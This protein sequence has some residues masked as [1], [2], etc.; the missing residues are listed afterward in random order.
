MKSPIRIGIFKPTN[1]RINNAFATGQLE[2]LK[3]LQ[4]RND[5]EIVLL[6][7]DR[8]F[9][10]NVFD[11]KHLK[12]NYIKTY[13]NKI[14]RKLFKIPYIKI[15]YYKNLDLNNF[16]TIITEGIH[17]PHL[18]YLFGLKCKIIFNDSITV[19][20]SFNKRK[21]ELFNK[22][23]N[24]GKSVVVNPKIKKLYKKYN[25]KIKSIVIGHSVSDN[26]KS[27][28][29]KKFNGKFIAIGRLSKEKGYETIFKA[30]KAL[31]LRGLSFTLDVYGEGI[32]NTR[33]KNLI[34]KLEIE[35]NV[36]IIGYLPH[37][38]LL[39]KINNY[40]IFISHPIETD[41]VAEAFNLSLAESMFAGIP[42]ITSDCGGMRSLYSKNSIIVKQFDYKDLADKIYELTKNEILLKKISENGIEFIGQNFTLINIV[43]KWENLLFKN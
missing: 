7:D 19:E 33:L 4:K 3:E 32:E 13:I 42:T 30:C 35:N 25:I 20:K 28:P 6:T 11:V 21:I 15:P 1:I 37:E 27:K 34:K 41:T 12:I 9:T 36:N 2:V 8:K 38:K 10:S 16:Q 26:I 5:I 39:K 23:F 31:K 14:L 17:Y 18:K 29:I 43:K 22:Y 24:N 40:S